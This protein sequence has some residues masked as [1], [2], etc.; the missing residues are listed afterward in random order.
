MGLDP[1][2]R[3][4]QWERENHGSPRLPSSKAVGEEV[5]HVNMMSKQ[6]R[7]GLQVQLLR[8]LPDGPGTSG[9]LRE[10]PG[11]RQLPHSEL[12]APRRNGKGHANDQDPVPFHSAGSVLVSLRTMLPLKTVLLDRGHPREQGGEGGQRTQCTH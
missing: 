10:G 11:S 5:A 7:P 1:Q 4:G 2:S 3:P 6:R 12:L 9:L 8:I